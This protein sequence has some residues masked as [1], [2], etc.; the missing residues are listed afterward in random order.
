MLLG[1]SATLLILCKGAFG[2]GFA[3]TVLKVDNNVDPKF[4]EFLDILAVHG[5]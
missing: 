3:G 1:P 2:E 5:H 4:F